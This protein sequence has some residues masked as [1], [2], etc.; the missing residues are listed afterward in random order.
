MTHRVTALL[1][2]LVAF[3]VTLT[4]WG[5]AFPDAWFATFHGAPR[6]D[7]QGYLARAAASWAAFA[8]LQLIALVRW[9]RDA[10]WLAVIAGVRL[11]DCL[12]DVTCLAAC[13]RATWQ[14]WVGFPLAGAGNLLVG[15]VLLRAHALA[16]T[17]ALPRA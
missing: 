6:V 14:A 11:A 8:V 12:T 16:T 13:E 4:V 2:A 10:A 5:L 9:R 15:V 17:S 3:D 1:G 7:P